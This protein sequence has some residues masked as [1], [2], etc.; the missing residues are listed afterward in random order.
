MDCYNWQG[1]A[2][3]KEGTLVECYT[4]DKADV[5]IKE[6]RG[7]SENHLRKK[8][9]QARLNRSNKFSPPYPNPIIFCVEIRNNK[10]HRAPSFDVASKIKLPLSRSATRSRPNDKN[11][12]LFC[13]SF[14]S[15]FDFS[16]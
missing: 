8:I 3:F 6:M 16:Y 15:H 5:N 10:Q 13:I 1:V 7:S 9:R 12:A 2:I 11:V 4:S 14:L